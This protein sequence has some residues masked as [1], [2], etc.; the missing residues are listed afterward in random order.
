VVP[1]PSHPAP[2]GQEDPEITDISDL[3]DLPDQLAQLHEAIAARDDLIRLIGHE[4]R[5]PLS[6]VYLQACHLMSEVQ[7][8]GEDGALEA[9]WLSPRLDRLMRGLERLLDRL[10]RLMDVAALQSHGE[11]ALVEDDVDLVAVVADAVH[12]S[13]G[14]AAAAGAEIRLGLPDQVIGRWD[15]IRLEQI[16]GSLLSNAIRYGGGAPIDI[17]IAASQDT[18]VLTVRDHGPGIAPEL[19]G[20]IFD[21]FDQVSPRPKH[22]GFGLGLWMV[23]R[24]CGAMNGSVALDGSTGQG[25]AFVVTLPRGTTA[26]NE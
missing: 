26:A 13:A 11:I 19:H 15:R 7:K 14:E 25:A 17:G 5:N 4:L 3:P 8:R 23:R 22:G 12:A 20:R 21:R 18:A 16:T 24:L 1:P 10:N 6:P 9:R 2:A